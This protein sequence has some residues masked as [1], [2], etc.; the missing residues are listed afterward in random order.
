MDQA[1]ATTATALERLCGRTRPT[2]WVT[3]A[4]P[5]IDRIACPWLV[6][7]FA[8]PDAIVHYVP[9][10]EVFAVAAAEGAV[11]FDLPGAPISHVGERC[12]FDAL[13]DALAL[14]TPTLDRLA[15]IVRGADTDRHDLAPESAGLHAIA[16]GLAKLHDDDQELLR[17]GMAVYDALFAYL[18]RGAASAHRWT[19]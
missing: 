16:L 7:R 9:A 3:R 6:R 8:D 11:A 4:R 18:E 17:A 5:K 13:L 19:P 15:V 2:R 1:L 10:A 14:R 12:S